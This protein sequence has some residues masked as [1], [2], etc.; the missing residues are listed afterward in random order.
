LEAA[1]HSGK[2]I[3]RLTWH[4][5]ATGLTLEQLTVLWRTRAWIKW[6]KRK[7][8]KKVPQFQRRA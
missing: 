4:F 7:K 5:L 2:E 1:L 3:V 6:K 8:S